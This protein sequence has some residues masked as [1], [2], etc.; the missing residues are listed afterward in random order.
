V[1][2]TLEGDNKVI[3]MQTANFLLKNFQKIMIQ[4]KPAILTCEFLEEFRDRQESFL[5]VQEDLRD[6]LNLIQIFKANAALLLLHAAQR[7]Q[8]KMEDKDM[9]D[10]FTESVPFGMN[11]ASIAYG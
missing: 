10:A 1:S 11:R 9:F 7:L 3:L 2:L 5:K 4:G 8:K 6:P